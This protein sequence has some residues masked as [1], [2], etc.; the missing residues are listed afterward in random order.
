M[1]NPEAMLEALRAMLELPAEATAD[2]IATALE[3]RGHGTGAAGA[4]FRVTAAAI[5]SRIT[6]DTALAIHGRDALV[7]LG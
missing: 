5:R 3:S 6:A 4:V 2:D 1:T 7:A